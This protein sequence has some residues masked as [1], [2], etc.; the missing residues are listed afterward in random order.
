VW[1]FKAATPATGNG[2][3]GLY[4]FDNGRV[5]TSTGASETYTVT[6]EQD[7]TVL[8]E[9]ELK[10][11]DSPARTWFHMALVDGVLWGRG[12]A[13]AVNTSGNKGSESTELKKIEFQ[14]DIIGEPASPREGSA[15]ATTL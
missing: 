6:E 14:T 5:T 3:L 2:D 7:G 9:I 12:E 4:T 10:D 8:V 13:L 15:A 11:E 1:K